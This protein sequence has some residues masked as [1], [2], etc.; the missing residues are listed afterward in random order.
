MGAHCVLRAAD[1]GAEGGALVSAAEH[2]RGC[3]RGRVEGGPRV[4]VVGGRAGA[5]GGGVGSG[6]G[7]SGGGGEVVLHGVG[8]GDMGRS[9]CGCVGRSGWVRVGGVVLEVL[10]VVVA[11]YCGGRHLLDG[12]PGRLA[13]A[14]AAHCAN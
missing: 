7:W 2:A 4:A 5:A 1:G 12:S 6:G 8:A 10:H 14:A 3:R 9:L 11:G 13:R